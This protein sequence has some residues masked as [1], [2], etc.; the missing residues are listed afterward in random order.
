MKG[1]KGTS[2]GQYIY[3]DARKQ[4][5]DG[6]FLEIASERDYD[7][8]RCDKDTVIGRCEVHLL[9]KV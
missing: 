6:F 1:S 3:A 8:V 9:P 7:D 4:E 2:P 5:G